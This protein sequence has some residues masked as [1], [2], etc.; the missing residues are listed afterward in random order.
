MKRILYIVVVLLGLATLVIGAGVFTIQSAPTY[1]VKD[2]HYHPIALNTLLTD[3]DHIATIDAF[4]PPGNTT[5]AG[6]ILNPYIPLTEGH[7]ALYQEIWWNSL[8]DE[9]HALIKES[10]FST[11]DIKA[12]PEEDLLNRLLSFDH[13]DPTS[14]GPYS[15]V[16]A[17]SPTVAFIDTP[18]PLIRGLIAVAKIRL[19]R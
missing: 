13:W 16:L 6:T 15:E 8:S 4:F 18:I 19:S 5:D 7:S 3:F 2:L 14:S 11:L 10:G 12:Y 1:N 9:H 17:T